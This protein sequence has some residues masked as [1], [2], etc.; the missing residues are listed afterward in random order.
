MFRCFGF[1]SDLHQRHITGVSAHLVSATIVASL[2]GFDTSFNSQSLGCNAQ[3]KDI[4][5]LLVFCH[6]GNRKPQ[7]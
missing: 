6:I 5:I 1:F 2:R 7:I 3:F 4:I